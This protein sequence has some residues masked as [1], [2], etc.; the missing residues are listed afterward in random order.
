MD[1][2]TNNNLINKRKNI[3]LRRR[4]RIRRSRNMRRKQNILIRRISRRRR[5]RSLLRITNRRSLLMERCHTCTISLCCIFVFSMLSQ[6]A[7]PSC[8]IALALLMAGSCIIRVPNMYTIS[9]GVRH[10]I[11]WSELFRLEFLDF[12]IPMRPH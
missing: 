7:P 3:N 9:G 8:H 12:F 11:S 10:V 6:R 2:N 4:R 5:R 1:T